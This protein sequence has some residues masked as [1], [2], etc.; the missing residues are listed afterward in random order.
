MT[1]IKKEHFVSCIGIFVVAISIGFYKG[2]SEKSDIETIPKPQIETE[3]N[4][5]TNEYY[6]E[7]AALLSSTKI[8]Q[9]LL[10]SKLDSM[11][12]VQVTSVID[13]TEI[14]EPKM[15]EIVATNDDENTDTINLVTQPTPLTEYKVQQ[16]EVLGTIARKFSV[17]V[18]ELMALNNIKNPRRVREG[19]TL[20]IPEPSIITTPEPLPDNAY[21]VKP[22]EVLGTIAR[23]FSVPIKQLMEENSI[24]DPKKVR[25][26]TILLIPD[27][28]IH[29]SSK[30]NQPD[31][32][33]LIV[34]EHS[35]EAV[36]THF[37][38]GLL[39]AKKQ[40]AELAIEEFKQAISLDPNH[41]G[42]HYNIASLYA[43][44]GN[45]QLAIEM[46][47]KS[48]TIDPS[49]TQSWFNLGVTYAKDDNNQKA[50]E[51][52]QRFIQ[53]AEGNETFEDGI[54]AAKKIIG[55]LESL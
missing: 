52:F 4:T 11:Q 47:E 36:N 48:L 44:N 30:I 49:Y 16:N 2:G 39:Y 46:F 14:E 28:S 21:V 22:G 32:S 34:P 19:T 40:Q 53:V 7:V 6:E 33:N 26:G 20:L 17:T 18:N 13:T 35:L 37:E 10:I 25:D 8:S 24:S 29:A 45:T 23:K 41:A 5:K 12:D 55:E 9:P 50:L 31:T 15:P 42:A 51:C 54:Q 43:L 27:T 1:K 3:I 38:A